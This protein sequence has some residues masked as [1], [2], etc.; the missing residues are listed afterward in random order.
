[1]THVLP[2]QVVTGGH[3]Q[4]S[5]AHV[6][7]ALENFRHAE[8]DGRLARARMPGEAH[9][10]G[11]RFGCETHLFTQPLYQ[12]QRGDLPDAGLDRLEADEFKIKFI[13]DILDIRISKRLIDVHLRVF[14]FEFRISNFGFS[15]FHSLFLMQS[16]QDCEF[17]I[18]ECRVGFIRDLQS[19]VD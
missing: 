15:A 1:M 6:A 10:Q 5:L 9:V 17:S 3:H 2:D 16:F 19:A 13:Q 14:D 7:Q 4:M 8:R 11:R 18:F 12:K